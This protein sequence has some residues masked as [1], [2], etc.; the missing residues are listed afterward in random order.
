M[1]QFEIFRT[2]KKFELDSS[3]QYEGLNNEKLKQLLNEKINKVATQFEKINAKNNSSNEEYLEIIKNNL[4]EIY[5]LSLDTDEKER[6]CLYFEEL[7][8]IIG[9][10]SS[11]GLLNHFMYGFDPNQPID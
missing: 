7:M 6:V 1:N 11:E 9:M 3:V 10:E 2:K 4:D 5:G 8:D